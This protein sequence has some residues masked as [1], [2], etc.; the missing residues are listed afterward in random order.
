M[1]LCDRIH[2]LGVGTVMGLPGDTNLELLHYIGSTDMHWGEVS[3][4]PFSLTWNADQRSKLEIPMSSMQLM[5]LTD[6]QES[7]VVLVS[8]SDPCREPKELYDG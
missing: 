6:I 7:R 4:S 3:N 2:Q 1:V 8:V 5:R